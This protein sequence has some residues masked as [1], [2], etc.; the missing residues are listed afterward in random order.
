MS[1]HPIINVHT[2]T[3]NFTCVPDGFLSNYV[4]RAVASIA[5][6]A[7]RTKILGGMVRSLLRKLPMTKKF[8]TLVSIGSNRTQLDVFETMLKSYSGV[9]C[10]FVILPMNFDNMGGGT[11]PARY[12]TQISEVEQIKLQYP[13]RM[14]PFLAVDPRMGSANFLYQFVKSYFEPSPGISRGFAGIKLYP[15]LGFFPFDPRLEQV[16]AY[17]EEHGIPIQTHCT[18]YG[19][20]Y[21]GKKLPPELYSLDSFNPTVYTTERHSQPQYAKMKELPPKDSSDNFLDPVNYLDILVK[22]PKLKL[23]IAHLGGDDEIP[24][25]TNEA[26]NIPAEQLAVKGFS[27]NTPWYSIV[28]YIM[29]EFKN[30]Y[31]DISYTL[32]NEKIWNALDTLI[33]GNIQVPS[34]EEKFVSDI[35]KRILFGTD[36]FMTITHKPEDRLYNEFI[37][38]LNKQLNNSEY[39]R[40]IAWDNPKIYLKSDFFAIA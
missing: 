7:L 23:C 13:D 38:Q 15:S 6:K 26:Q 18:R 29:K 17:A 8:A 12:L 1:K 3:F 9:D 30:V 34:G 40:A 14:I 32:Y 24:V 21:A 37:E 35:P 19:A 11:P 5:G 20:Y 2:H 10:Y 25:T 36:Y 16:Y 22:F 39:W 27:P 33:A 28:L 4:N 31:A